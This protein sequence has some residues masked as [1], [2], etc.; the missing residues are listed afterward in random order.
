VYGGVLVAL[1]GP[2]F[3]WRWSYYGYLLPNTFYAKVGST[4]AQLARGVNYLLDAAAHD[5]LLIAGVLGGLLA[6]LGLRRAAPGQGRVLLLIGG[7]VALVL[8]YIIA[9]GGDWMPGRRFVVPLTPL[10]ALLAA[11]GAASLA[12]R[13]PHWRVVALLVVAVLVVGQV[14]TLPADTSREYSLI[15]RQDYLLR[16]FREIGRWIHANTPPDTV[17]AVDCGGAI[18]YYAQ[19]P[20]IDLLGLNDEYIAH[21]PSETIGTGKTGHEK[22]APD[23]VLARQPAIVPY[24]CV[25]Y[26]PAQPA[27]QASYHIEKFAGPE[28]HAVQLYVRTGVQLPAPPPDA[29]SQ[30]TR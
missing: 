2:Y 26:M 29:R 21:Q 30:G 28:G 1:Y 27:F 22:A 7:V 3:L 13:G 4:W 20:T 23:Y 14:R 9:V 8:A 24:K 18:P 19:R 10:L 11:W 16:R 17:I 15:W 5:P 12:R 6:W 25:A